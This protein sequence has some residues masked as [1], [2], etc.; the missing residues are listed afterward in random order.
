MRYRNIFPSFL[1]VKKINTILHLFRPEN[2]TGP[3]KA[4][5]PTHFEIPEYEFKAQDLRES[6]LK[7]GGTFSLKSNLV[8]KA[9]R[10]QKAVLFFKNILFICMEFLK[11]LNFTSFPIEIFPDP[12]TVPTV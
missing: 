1:S 3:K 10:N 9:K 11:S 2:V 4:T 6:N 12:E 8:F 5:L 7:V